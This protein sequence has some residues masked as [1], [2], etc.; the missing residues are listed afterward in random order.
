M[1]S[2]T[3]T[4]AMLEAERAKASFD[5]DKLLK[6]MGVDKRREQFLAARELFRDSHEAFREDPHEEY[7]SYVDQYKSQL[8]RAAHAIEITR[9]NPSFMMKHMAGKVHMRDLFH[10]NGIGIHFFMFLTFLKSNS[11]DA[12]KAAWLDLAL[13]RRFIGCYCQTGLGHGSNLRGIETVATFDKATDEFV[14]HSPTLTS[15]KWWPT[16]MYASTHA[17]VMANLELDGKVCG[18]QGFFMQLRDEHGVLM[19][20]VEVGEMG[21]KIDHAKANIGYARFTRVRVP[22][23]NMF[24]RFFKVSRDGAW[25]APSRGWAASRTSA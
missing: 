21:P 6:M 5:V 17:V 10:T 11:T 18:V 22:R 2:T 14:I 7:M 23:F 19:P 4:A 9:S 13:E 16:G 1:A 25:N 24:A 8:S 20:G 15:L 12:Q 3:D